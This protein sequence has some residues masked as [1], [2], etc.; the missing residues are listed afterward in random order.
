MPGTTRVVCNQNYFPSLTATAC[1]APPTP[2]L[3]TETF[4][5]GCAPYA[6]LIA[7]DK[8]TLVSSVCSD[9]ANKVLTCPAPNGVAFVMPTFAWFG[10]DHGPGYWTSYYNFNY[11]VPTPNGSG[12][13]KLAFSVSG[14]AAAE[15]K[16]GFTNGT[17]GGGTWL[18]N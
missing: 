10:A 6:A 16:Y 7:T 13:Y 1:G 17:F 18:I 2:P 14:N 3:D 12:G 15:N 8:A 4:T 11:G 5:D 9:S